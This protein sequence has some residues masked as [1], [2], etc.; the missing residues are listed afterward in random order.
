MD[1]ADKVD[2]VADLLAAMA[3]PNRLMVLCHLLDGELAV[4]ELLDR[5]PL[6]QSTMSQHLGKM[7]ALKLVAARRSAQTIHYR[8]AS[9]EVR[10]LLALLK[11]LYC[12]P[13]DGAAASC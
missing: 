1:L 6:A 4:H 7:R 12:D 5:V 3:N 11:E 2:D 13:A 8:L 10:R 9:E